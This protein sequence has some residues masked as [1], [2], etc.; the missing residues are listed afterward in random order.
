[1]TFEKGGVVLG[2]IPKVLINLVNEAHGPQTTL[3]IKR[4]AGCDE[5]LD[6][7][8]N[9]VYQDDTWRRLVTA[10]TEVLGCSGEELEEEYARYFLKDAKRRWPAWFQMSKTARQFLERHPAVHNNFADAVRDSQSRDEIKDK[11]R[12]EKLED[13][14][15]THYRSPNRH[16][17]LYVSLAREVLLLYGEEATIEEPKC[18]K[19]GDLECE[20]W[21]SWS[22]QVMVN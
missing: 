13:K 10:T 4:R 11:F 18:V 7:R 12:I 1:M 17:H 6:F 16:C 19:R 9:E 15:I 22:P 21:I 14:I 2:L 20:I 8:I 5:L 3:E